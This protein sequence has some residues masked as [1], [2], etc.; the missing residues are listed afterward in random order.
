MTAGSD[1]RGV[2][3][4]GVRLRLLLALAVVTPLG[5]ATKL[6]AGPAER[7]VA[8][9]AG[10]ALYVVFWCLLVAALRPR[11]SPWII[12]A[13]VLAVTSALECLQLW[14]PAPLQAIRSTWLGHALIGSVFQ[15]SD[16]PYYVA[17]A[18][19]AAVVVRGFQGSRPSSRGVMA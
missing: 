18:L 7:W 1:G 17:G 12:S 3:D 11:L 8:T 2:T 14:H 4:S 16:F 19:L 10:G 6:Y 13:A 15:W 9:H 5:F